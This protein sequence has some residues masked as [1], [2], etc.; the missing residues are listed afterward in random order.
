MRMRQIVA[1]V[2]SLGVIG[3]AVYGFV[4]Q[5]SVVP[6]RVMF[7][8]VTTGEMK[9]IHRD[10][11]RSYPVLN[12]VT[13]QNTLYPCYKKDNDDRFYLS[14]RFRP[15]LKELGENNKFV[16]LKTMIVTTPTEK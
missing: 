12:P 6:N 1:A 3:W 9:E 8:D 10:D 15:A 5:P 13:G 4:D 14:S 7:V 16:N 2:L 11:F